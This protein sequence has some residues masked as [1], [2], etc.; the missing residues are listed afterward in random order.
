MTKGLDLSVPRPR[1][2]HPLQ[3]VKQVDVL[4]MVP[5]LGQEEIMVYKVVEGC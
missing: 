4:N 3:E 1:A 2:E 5:D